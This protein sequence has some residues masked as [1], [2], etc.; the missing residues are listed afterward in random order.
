MVLLKGGQVSN[1]TWHFFISPMTGKGGGSQPLR[2]A[3]NTAGIN[4]LEHF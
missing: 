1:Y 4:Y 3:L 2:N